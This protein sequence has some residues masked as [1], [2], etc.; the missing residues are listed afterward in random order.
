MKC[1]DMNTSYIPHFLMQE[2]LRSGTNPKSEI[3]NYKQIQIT[4]IQN[5]KHK[6]S[7]FKNL[8]LGFR[9]CL[10]FRILRLEFNRTIVRLY[11]GR[12]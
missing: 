6:K 2:F 8:N 1:K 5:Q 10:G 9:N 7:N 4:Q 12:R 11:S 3:L